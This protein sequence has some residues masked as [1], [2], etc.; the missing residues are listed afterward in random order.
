MPKR[1]PVQLEGSLAIAAVGIIVAF[2][3][4]NYAYHYDVLP[5]GVGR[6]AVGYFLAVQ[7]RVRH[8][9]SI[10]G[11]RLPV[12]VPRTQRSRASAYL[13]AHETASPQWQH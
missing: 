8:R 9:S 2:S 12:P 1:V 5:L 7:L 3:V 10:G 11:P 6:S 4:M 13:L